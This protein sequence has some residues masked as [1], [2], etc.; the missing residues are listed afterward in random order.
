M[1]TPWLQSNGTHCTRLAKCTEYEWKRQMLRMICCS[2]TRPLWSQIC[3]HQKKR[4]I[5]GEVRLSTMFRALSLFAAFCSFFCV[6]HKPNY[7]ACVWAVCRSISL[8][9]CVYAF[10]PSP[11]SKWVTICLLVYEAFKSS[12]SCFETSMQKEPTFDE[13]LITHS[14]Q[15]SD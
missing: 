15:A 14:Q 2:S 1:A 13:R 6:H 4:F 12:C 7:T 11:F 8:I 3:T 5:L 10:S 9:L